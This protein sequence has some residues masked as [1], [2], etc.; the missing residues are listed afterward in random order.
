MLGE[1]RE[2][3]RLFAKS[4]GTRRLQDDDHLYRQIWETDAHPCQAVPELVHVG[5][6]DSPVFEGGLFASNHYEV[7]TVVDGKREK[8]FRQA[9]PGPPIKMHPEISGR[10][11]TMIIR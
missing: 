1:R 10:F 9:V 5:G 4:L 3:D 11:V 7:R 8:Y 2:P 6:N